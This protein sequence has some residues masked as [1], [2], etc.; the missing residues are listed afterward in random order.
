M[1]GSDG[2]RA[3][4]PDDDGPFLHAAYRE[5]GNL[6][7]AENTDE[8]RRAWFR[9]IPTFLAALAEDFLRESALFGALLACVVAVFAAFSSDNVGWLIGLIASGVAGATL[10]L[11]AA[12]QR[13][14]VSRQWAVFIGVL[15]VEVGLIV[16]MEQMTS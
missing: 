8:R 12:L 2:K 10:V 3:A 6:D 9:L 1:T 4:K 13:W 5:A 7:A 16:L 14:R 15:A 11:C